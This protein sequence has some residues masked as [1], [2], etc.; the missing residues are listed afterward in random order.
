[1]TAPD[2]SEVLSRAVALDAPSGAEGTEGERME[3]EEEVTVA[4]LEEGKEIMVRELS[5]QERCLG[6]CCVLFAMII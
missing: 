1:M 4:P 6:R 3:V 2:E 5:A